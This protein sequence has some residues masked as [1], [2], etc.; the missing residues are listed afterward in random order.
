MLT[1]VL[2]T[3]R[4]L[5]DAI[6]LIEATGLPAGELSSIG[7]RLVLEDGGFRF[8]LAKPMD[9]PMYIVAG[10]A[11]LGLAG[12]DVL[13]E[14]GAPLV[15][16]A[17]TGM[18]VCRM[19]LAAPR[20][21]SI[22]GC[23]APERRPRNGRERAGG[24]PWIR[25]ATKY[26]GIADRYFSSRGLQAE[27]IHL[28]GSVELAPRL[29]MSEC[30]VDIVQTGSTLAANG[31]VERATICPVSLRLVASKRSVVQRQREIRDIRDA[32]TAK[33]RIVDR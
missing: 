16:L 8:I 3:G 24:V 25:V 1:F 29:G 26:P 15:D 9:V 4:V 10:T 33:G 2:P 27:I 31:L 5:R 22:G 12:S 21:V 11:D 19:V 14:T 17:D 18:G 30:I 23:N 32:M 20:D 7:R 28:N 13:M 6:A